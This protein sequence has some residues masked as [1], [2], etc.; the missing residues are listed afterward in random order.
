M[1]QLKFLSLI[2]V[3]LLFHIEDCQSQ[4]DKTY[5]CNDCIIETFNTYE[6]YE[7][8]KS[9]NKIE[10][11]EKVKTFGANQQVLSFKSVLISA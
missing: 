1:K 2:G 8:N 7:S 3:I 9:S 5:F 4:D 11:A 6:D 10:N